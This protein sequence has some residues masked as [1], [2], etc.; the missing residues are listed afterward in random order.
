[1]ASRPEEFWAE[2]LGCAESR[3]AAPGLTLVAHPAEAVF[4]LATRS[5]VVVAAPDA[6]HERLRAVADPRA[7]IVPA[8][9]RTLLPEHALL[10][11]PACVAYRHDPVSPASGPVEIHSAGEERL[12]ALRAA[13]APEEWRHANLE[14]SEPPLFACEVDGAIAAAAGFQRLLDRVAHIGVLAHPAHRRRGL[15]RRAVQ[16]ATALAQAHGLLAQYQTLDSNAPALA[17]AARLGF[18]RFATTLAARL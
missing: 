18:E 13:V 8:R 12:G 3:F 10:I 17:I 4:V 11:G 15:A 9:L 7:L 1:M 6:L 5:A 2:R 14:A 16:S